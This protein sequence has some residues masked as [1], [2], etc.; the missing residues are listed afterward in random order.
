MTDEIITPETFKLAKERGFNVRI[1]RCGGFPECIC[2]DPFPTQS[3]LQR[4]LREI[5]GIQVY[6]YSHTVKS[7]NMMQIYRDYV[8]YIN[9]RELN[10]ARDEEYQT[11]EKALEFGLQEGLKHVS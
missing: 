6:V 5:H 7:T 3:L 11:Y 4:W 8:A 9:G 2:N 1:C 10:D